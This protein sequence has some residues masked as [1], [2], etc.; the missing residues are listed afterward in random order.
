M[1]CD[2]IQIQDIVTYIIF[3]NIFTNCGEDAPNLR[4]GCVIVKKLT[5]LLI[6]LFAAAMIF[7]GC[8]NGGTTMEGSK[9]PQTTDTAAESLEETES[10]SSPSDDVTYPENTY[11]E[12]TYPEN[13]YP[14]NTYPEN[15]YPENT[16]PENTYPD[17]SV[18]TE[19][20]V[21]TEP[22]TTEPDTT[23]PATTEPETTAPAT[24]EP[25]TTAPV[26]TEPET[27]APVTTEPETTEPETTEPEETEPLPVKVSSVT[28]SA[29]KTAIYVGDTA[30]LTVRVSPSEADNKEV[31][32]SVTSGSTVVSVSSSGVITAKK[33]GSATV[34]AT[35]KD[36]SG[37]Y[38]EITVTVKERSLWEGS[39]TASDPFLIRNVTDLKN[40]T[41]VLDKKGYYF[42]QVADIDLSGEAKWIVIGEGEKPFRHNYDGGGYKISDLCLDGEAMGL[43][44]CAEDAHFE[45]IN[46]VNAHTADNAQTREN[47]TGLYPGTDGITA[48]LVGYATGCTFDSCTASVNFESSNETTAGLVGFVT[49]KEGQGDLMVNC[50]V[51]GNIC[52]A[53]KIGGLIAYIWKAFYNEDFAPDGAPDIYVKN[54]TADVDITVKVYCMER[55][56]I[57]GLI[58]YANLVKVEKCRTEGNINVIEGDVGGLIGYSL[59][60]TEV[61][62]CSSSVDIFCST[63]SAYGGVSA[64]GLIGQANAY[65][66]VHDC[67]ATGD[68]NAPNADWSPCRDSSPRNGGP[69]INYYN[70]CG[71]LIG[72]VKTSGDYSDYHKLNIYNNYATGKVNVPGIC[73]DE[74]LYCHGALIG[75]VYDIYTYRY[76]TDTSK[77]DQSD[78]AGF[79]STCILRFEDNYN[80]EDLRTYYTPVNEYAGSNTLGMQKPTY[81]AMPQHEYVKIITEAELKDQSTFEGWDFTNIWKMGDSGPELR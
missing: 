28:V 81:S 71:S 58:G 38:G 45:N 55:C 8:D 52:G 32:F 66:V 62:R 31:S 56:N 70:P 2:I 64:G 61:S 75:L 4:K 53:G 43:I 18:G 16:Y 36:G 54:C 9:A 26:T 59:Y 80:I 46:I 24:T 23:A 14:E 27:T 74:R 44:S 10:E 79:S 22:D 77:K 48:A 40:L 37:K 65:I 67:Y 69:N 78:W 25:D 34:R 5:S 49:L 72:A 73:E 15:T 19:E 76:I 63:D 11:P 7:T 3:N 29:D 41:N 47:Q 60:A 1:I 13:T 12:N 30:T 21:T 51:T 33:A 50:R 6:F 35:A 57:G 20:P 17:T 39:G 68:V 42:K